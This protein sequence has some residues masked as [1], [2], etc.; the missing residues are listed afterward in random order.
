MEE[1]EQDE[2]T[3]EE[4]AQTVLSQLTITTPEGVIHGE[5]LP[6]WLA[7]PWAAA[8]VDP[9]DPDFESSVIKAEAW[10]ASR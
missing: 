8:I 6:E 7:L 3:W 5:G 1:V 2:P 9:H 10:L 4:R